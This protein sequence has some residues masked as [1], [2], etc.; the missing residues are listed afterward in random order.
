[1]SEKIEVVYNEF[2]VKQESTRLE[3]FLK[4]IGTLKIVDERNIYVM[5]GFYEAEILEES[6]N[7]G[8]RLVIHTLKPRSR[9]LIKLSEVIGNVYK[10]QQTIKIDKAPW[11]A[12]HGEDHDEYDELLDKY[13]NSEHEKRRLDKEPLAEPS[14]TY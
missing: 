11:V 5:P 12:R 2:H 6:K 7:G 1:M 9:N 8:T 13:F 3:D 4:K 14:S 10:Y